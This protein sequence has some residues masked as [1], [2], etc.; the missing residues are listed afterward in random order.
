MKLS[1]KFAK[2]LI[3]LLVA[4]LLI[5]ILFACDPGDTT[6]DPD[7]GAGEGAGLE[8]T[9][10]LSNLADR[11]D[12]AISAVDSSTKSKGVVSVL[13]NYAFMAEDLKYTITYNVNYDYATTSRSRSDIYLKIY[14]EE[15]AKTRLMF[16]YTAGTLYVE[17]EDGRQKITNFGSS[18]MFDIFYAFVSYFDMSTIVVD[19][20]FA[21]SVEDLSSYIEAKKLTMFNTSETSDNISLTGVNFDTKKATVNELITSAFGRFGTT[22]DAISE[23]LL[24]VKFSRLAAM[25]LMTLDANLVEFYSTDKVFH[26]T[27]FDFSGMLESKYDFSLVGGFSVET[28]RRDLA[29]SEWDDE[30]KVEDAIDKFVSTNNLTEE[31]RQAYLKK[32]SYVTADISRSMYQGTVNLNLLGNIYDAEIFYDIDAEDDL[33]SDFSLRITDQGTVVASAYYRQ[34]EAYVDLGD[35]Y[36]SFNK[37]FGLADYNLP[38]VYSSTF[39]LS[40]AIDRGY[41]TIDL[42]IRDLLTTSDDQ[43]NGLWDIAQEKIEVNGTITT[44]YIDKKLVTSI[45]N[46]RD[47]PYSSANVAVFLADLI[48]IDKEIIETYFTGE[49]LDTLRLLVSHDTRDNSIEFKLQMTATEADAKGIVSVDE[50]VR[51]NA[52][53]HMYT[54]IGDVSP[55]SS[56]FSANGVDY[57]YYQYAGNLY[58]TKQRS[59]LKGTMRGDLNTLYVTL[60]GGQEVAYTYG[61]ATLGIVELKQ[62]ETVV[63]KYYTAQEYLTIGDTTYYFTM[64]KLAPKELYSDAARTTVV[65]TLDYDKYMFKVENMYYY[66]GASAVNYVTGAIYAGK[67]DIFTQ[68]FSVEGVT[69]NYGH[70]I[71]YRKGETVGVITPQDKIVIATATPSQVFLK[72]I[73]NGKVGLYN[74]KD[75]TQEIVGHYDEATRSIVFEKGQ[76]EGETFLIDVD[77]NLMKLYGDVD[78]KEKELTMHYLGYTYN[79]NYGGVYSTQEGIDDLVTINLVGAQE[80]RWLYSA[81]GSMSNK[82]DNGFFAVTITNG[83]VDKTYYFKHGDTRVFATASLDSV[84]DRASINFRRGTISLDNVEYLLGTSTLVSVSTEE[85][86]GIIDMIDRLVVIDTGVYSY[87]AEGLVVGLEKA[88]ETL[89]QG[90]YLLYN[91]QSDEIFSMSA[92]LL[93]DKD[94]MAVGSFVNGII[95]F[96]AGTFSGNKYTS[97]SGELRQVVGD[98]DYN[99]QAVMIDGA[100]YEYREDSIVYVVRGDYHVGNKTI[101]LGGV[102]YYVEGGKVYT[103]ISLAQQVGTVDDEAGKVVL[104]GVDYYYN[105][106]DIEVL[107]HGYKPVSYPEDLG[108]IFNGEVTISQVNQLDISSFLGAFIGDAT[109]VNTP[110]TLSLGE[111]LVYSIKIAYHNDVPSMYAVLEHQDNTGA[112]INKLFTIASAE[113]VVGDLLV[114]YYVMGDLLKFRTTED[115]I[116][117]ALTAFAGDESVFNTD[118]ATAA[119]YKIFEYADISFMEDGLAYSI[120]YDTATGTDPIYQ[121]L[122]L[123][124]LSSTGVFS[125]D[126]DL[127]IPEVAVVN[128]GIADYNT[129]EISLPEVL[130]A[131]SIHE[132]NWIK[133]VDV[134][135]GD[136]WFYGITIPYI[137]SSIA[138]VDGKTIYTPTA[139]LF[140]KTISYTLILTGERGTSEV[141]DIVNGMIEIDPWDETP[142][143]AKLLAYFDNGSI[144]EVN[145]RIVGFD[146]NTISEYGN[147]IWNSTLQIAE[148]PTYD[149]IISEGTIGETTFT[150]VPV[151]VKCRILSDVKATTGVTSIIATTTIDPYD[152]D[153]ECNKAGDHEMLLASSGNPYAVADAEERFF[154]RWQDGE[155]TLWS[156]MP[157]EFYSHYTNENKEL[158]GYEN[159]YIKW[160]FDC[161]KITFR[162]EEIHAKAAEIYREE[163][164]EEGNKVYVRC[165]TKDIATTVYVISKLADHLSLYNIETG[166]KENDGV[167]TVDSL[168]QS[169]YTMPVRSTDNYMILLYFADG[170]FRVVGDETL[171]DRYLEDGL[172][173]GNLCDGVFNIALDWTYDVADYLTIHGTTTPLGGG[174]S[175]VNTAVLASTAVGSQD[176]KLTVREPSRVVEVS[177]SISGYT[178]VDILNNVVAR[179]ENAFGYNTV[180]WTGDSSGINMPFEVNPYQFSSTPLPETITVAVDEASGSGQTSIKYLTYP[181]KSWDE[182]TNVVQKGAD[183]KY[184][185][186]YPTAE[187]SIFQAIATIGDGAVETEVSVII[188]NIDAKYAYYEFDGFGKKADGDKT[189]LNVDAYSPYNLPKSFKIY[190]E[191]GSEPMTYDMEQFSWYVNY[192]EAGEKHISQY[193]Q[194]FTA[195][196]AGKEYIMWSDDDY[197]AFYQFVTTGQGQFD[198]SWIDGR[199]YFFD[200]NSREITLTAYIPSSVDGDL[201]QKIELTV[202]VIEMTDYKIATTVFGSQRENNTIIDIDT[203][204]AESALLMSYVNHQATDGSVISILPLE[205]YSPATQKSYTYYQKITWTDTDSALQLVNTLTAIGGAEKSVH[206][207][208][209]TVLGGSDIAITFCCLDRR[210]DSAQNVYFGALSNISEDI[211]TTSYTLAS[212]GD[213]SLTINLHKAYALTLLKEGKSEYALPS[214]FFLAALKS[215]SIM[216]ASAEY[217]TYETNMA[218]VVENGVYK[219]G[220][221]IP[222]DFDESVLGFSADGAEADT[223]VTFSVKI[224]LGSALDYIDVMIITTADSVYSSPRNYHLDIYANDGIGT[225]KYPNGYDIPTSYVVEY[226][227][228]GTVTYTDLEWRSGSPS[229]A[230]ITKI[231]ASRLTNDRA[232]FALYT[233]LPDGSPVSLS[234]IIASKNIGEVNYTASTYHDGERE[235]ETVTAES[236]VISLKNIYE[237]YDLMVVSGNYRVFDLSKLPNVVLPHKTIDFVDNSPI[238]Q[239]PITFR[240]AWNLGTFFRIDKNGN[241]VCSSKK[242]VNGVT[243]YKIA[244]ATI[245][246]YG[247]TSQKITLHVTIEDK[248][249]VNVSAEGYDFRYDE[250][251]G[252]QYLYVDP[253]E[254]TIIDGKSYYIWQKALPESVTLTLG[255]GTT[256]TVAA[257]N[258]SYT[259]EGRAID[260]LIYNHKQFTDTALGE[261]V[262]TMR[263]PDG[264]TFDITVVVIDREYDRVELPYAAKD[265]STKYFN[266]VYYIDPYNSATYDVPSVV[267]VV[268]RDGESKTLTLDWAKYS[269][270]A[271][272][273][274]LDN[275]TVKYSGGTYYYRATLAAYRYV[276]NVLTPIADNGNQHIEVSVHV[277]DRS[278]KEGEILNIAGRVTAQ[279]QDGV[280]RID[281]TFS[282]VNGEDHIGMRLSDVYPESLTSD[283]F[284]SLP[285]DFVNSYADMLLSYPTIDWASATDSVI[286]NGM[287]GEKVSG[288]LYNSTVG[289][290]V[291]AYIVTDRLTLTAFDSATTPNV[292]AQGNIY[293]Y[294]NPYTGDSIQ[295]SYSFL[296]DVEIW[297]GASWVLSNSVSL[298][299]YT[300]YSSSADQE[301]RAR[302]L[303]YWTANLSDNNAEDATFR[304]SNSTKDAE[305]VGYYSKANEIYF[306]TQALQVKYFR[307]D[308]GLGETDNSDMDLAE[309]VLDPLQPYLPTE[310][311]DAEGFLYI[312]KTTGKDVAELV[313]Q[314][315]TIIGEY[316]GLWQT[317]GSVKIK[318]ADSNQNGIYDAFENMTYTASSTRIVDANIDTSREENVAFKVRMYYLDRTAVAIYTDR[319]TNS[320]YGSSTGDPQYDS[321]TSGGVTIDPIKNYREG[322]YHLMTRLSLRF[323]SNPYDQNAPE[324]ALLYKAFEHYGSALDVVGLDIS[325]YYIAGGG[326]SLAGTNQAVECSLVSGTVVGVARPGAEYYVSLPAGVYTFDLSVTNRTVTGTSLPT[327][328]YE[329]KTFTVV[330]P[331]DGSVDYSIDPY[332]VNLPENFTITLG[333]GA[334]AV[335]QPYS[336]EML[337]DGSYPFTD[338]SVLTKPNVIQGLTSSYVTAYVEICGER[339]Y[340]NFS[341]KKR[342]ITIDPSLSDCTIIDGRTHI[343]GGTI[344][345]RAAKLDAAIAQLPTHMYYDF[346]AK[347]YARVPLTYN[348]SDLQ[349]LTK[350]GTY[351]V[352]AELGIT[353]EGT[354]I[355]FNVVVVDAKLYEIRT[356]VDAFGNVQETSIYDLVYDKIIVSVSSSGIR[357]EDMDDMWTPQ[358]IT[359]GQ[360]DSL[361]IE[362][363]SYDLEAKTATFSCLYR[364]Q[365]D[366]FNSELAGDKDGNKMFIFTLVVPLVVNQVD[367]YVG[368]ATLTQDVVRYALGTEITLT[369]LP[370]AVYGQ[371]EYAVYWD[372]TGRLGGDVVDKY[373]AGTYRIYGEVLTGLRDVARFALDVIIEKTDISDVASININDLRYEYTGEAKAYWAEKISFP[374]VTFLD[375]NGEEYTPECKFEFSQ[376]GVNWIDMEFV[377]VGTYYLRVSIDDANVTGSRTFVI[378]ISRA[379]INGNLISFADTTQTYTGAPLQPTVLYDGKALPRH[380]KYSFSF[381]RYENGVRVDYAQAINATTDGYLYVAVLEFEDND[382]Y[383]FSS[384]NIS[385][386]YFTIERREVSYQLATERVY[387]GNYEHIAIAGLPSTYASEGVEVRYTYTYTVNGQTYTT[388]NPIKNVGEYRVSVEI[389]GGNNYNSQNLARES[390]VITP[391]T[392]TVIVEG[393]ECTYPA[394]KPLAPVVRYE[395]KQGADVA[396][397]DSVLFGTLRISSPVSAF[398]TPTPGRYK[399]YAE[400]LHSSNYVFNYVCGDYVVNLPSDVREL[401]ADEV[402]QDVVDSYTG[403]SLKLYLKAADYGTLTIDKPG[404]TVTLIGECNLDGTYGATFDNITLVGGSLELSAVGLLAV[405]NTKSLVVKSTALSVIMTKVAF[406]GETY[407]SATVANGSVAIEIEAGYNAIFSMTDVS[408][409]YRAMGLSVYGGKLSIENS[410]IS[411]TASGIAM[412]GGSIT[413]VNTR[414]THATV[415]AM[416]LASTDLKDNYQLVN[417]SFSDNAVAIK[418]I[419]KLD[420]VSDAAVVS[421]NEFRRNESNF[422]A[423][424]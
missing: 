181:I 313:A 3:L 111:K 288:N 277:L 144:G 61:T 83:G 314:G 178:R 403:S 95:T 123:S 153:Q 325:N 13:S 205:M 349:K 207:E 105:Q 232:S 131:D 227:K 103:D 68:T 159:F 233:T 226:T 392:L 46:L 347:D 122:G 211:L 168:R 69:Y 94:G 164:D 408:I 295:D 332:N 213:K 2:I 124:N 418:Y 140:G 31:T 286:R 4:T 86:A 387:S 391:A 30:T 248:N 362:S 91:G 161:N 101:E 317:I 32:Y 65:N 328:S 5:G 364:F 221:A 240:V 145:Y 154:I 166:I 218:E 320:G 352:K 397:A 330:N 169:T 412:R 119:L 309:F 43:R 302:H 33:K 174:S 326:I 41:E 380:V 284:V 258:L 333:S 249:I 135:L 415:C 255:D 275:I 158:K 419:T 413:M 134:K 360:G 346:G 402:L 229:G 139:S 350:V 263:L 79:L 10:I 141:S 373:R 344:Y 112:L 128:Q 361:E 237:L 343:N 150:A 186:R 236:G 18:G 106:S 235:T 294:F 376:D 204:D 280:L 27:A 182:S 107:R 35:L 93:Y 173:D 44:L 99:A 171:K 120:V 62:G 89:D 183:G 308:L 230:P 421:G 209:S 189:I 262:V 375:I 272:V 220:S 374:G 290:Q 300:A 170:R 404:L 212:N 37:A 379:E 331:V 152:Y 250:Q 203:Y 265:G 278:I 151:M 393:I 12:S 19:K 420:I 291:D 335:N 285:E 336:F 98:V 409:A 406:Y 129:P 42:L 289:Q 410:S 132:V 228:S 340:F 88:G 366:T 355:L 339:Y 385:A 389:L 116:I 383:N 17:T 63:G 193:S 7:N 179:T 256:Y 390:Y 368:Q 287:A 25:Q 386:P 58:S 214:E 20:T 395:G 188:R 319:A 378:D 115:Q 311:Q 292:G 84:V 192:G 268:F 64:D 327:S 417:N 157:I 56:K 40:D 201:E 85:T 39:S 338:P 104:L 356:V 217:A 400:G 231:E 351:Q 394:T 149:V 337:A 15:T 270:S 81:V 78:Y 252:K 206:V 377:N 142:R 108:F 92:N 196:P 341:I 274:K 11:L 24:G 195:D 162:G 180:S 321:I 222:T 241:I 305:S 53:K 312:N 125:V 348:A 16:Y 371:E 175:S 49:E 407:T 299:F 187:A 359:I 304:L 357:L 36:T 146:D 163:L 160:A 254:E 70:G 74:E 318:W 48:G 130:M 60:S 396:I 14:D 117:T 176:I 293:I 191:E 342:A 367:D 303:I 242:E 323:G 264:S 100:I 411:Y 234:I 114:D 77:N 363:V 26:R 266:K 133:T 102:S 399:I 260:T 267:S 225:F 358:Y 113:D 66:V 185:L 148:Y 238:G 384:I 381:Y 138:V 259:A 416:Y 401:G 245:K 156:Y 269:D 137:E 167:Y 243:V 405:A 57:Y 296:F 126:Y 239:Q 382:N 244:E 23:K 67:F 307:L 28:T 8:K 87:T 281:R 47:E 194:D 109:G 198:N 82:L 247:S 315:Y 423:Q 210:I 215:V 177:G 75:E 216:F 283:C 200:N 50:A 76:F 219:L 29:V 365:E 398:V 310:I 1:A 414:I 297:D 147:A 276:G 190:L 202:N 165:A 71:A 282:V 197:E 301:G 21:S 422:L 306:T 298:P 329:N 251:A 253:Y 80:T 369:S 155:Q 246:G 34:G 316:Y 370:K 424:Q 372:V 97:I 22:Y 279:G 257:G 388:S 324:E 59:V 52:L 261:K 9:V 353:E 6:P 223:T 38:R 271:M 143:P 110:Y 127:V 273:D 136:T 54:K 90:R 45:N 72:K 73:E 172:I 121:L 345:I 118:N 354:N 322:S 51:D 96:T 184:Y 208:G 224:G 199:Y 55:L 334:N